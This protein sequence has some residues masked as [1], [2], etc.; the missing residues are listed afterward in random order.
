MDACWKCAFDFLPKVDLAATVA[1]SSTIGELR[2]Q[3]HHGINGLTTAIE[4]EKQV[5][6]LLL[7]HS[8]T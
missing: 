1:Q 3:G 5:V 7:G 6:S 2:L 8:L 4:V